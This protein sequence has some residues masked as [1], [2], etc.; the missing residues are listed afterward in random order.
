VP[1]F[2]TVAV[3]GG[4]RLRAGH[5]LLLELENATDKNY[6]GI[7]WGMDAPGVGLSVLYVA[8]F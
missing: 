3:R 5:E 6:R 8:R 1:G 2:L 4:V 7:A